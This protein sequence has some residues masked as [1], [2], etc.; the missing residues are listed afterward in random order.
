MNQKDFKEA[1][2]FA[3]KSLSAKSNNNKTQVRPNQLH[4]ITFIQVHNS[5]IACHYYGL[6]GHISKNYRKHELKFK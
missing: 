1:K 5:H 3:S 4:V 2:A 6:F